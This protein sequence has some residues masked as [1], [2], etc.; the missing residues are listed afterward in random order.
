MGLMDP[1]MYKRLIEIFRVELSEQIQAITDCLLVL[2]KTPEDP[3]GEERINTI[4]RAAHN[5]KGSARGTGLENIGDIAHCLEDLFSKFRQSEARPNTA[6]CN[7]CLEALDCMGA[8]MQAHIEKTEP[9]FDLQDLLKKLEQA[10]NAQ[11]PSPKN[12]AK[13]QSTNT[14]KSEKKKDEKASGDAVQTLTADFIRIPKEK[15]NELSAVGDELLSV[16]IKNEDLTSQMKQL[17]SR[18]KSTN[19]M[20]QTVI[21]SIKR[22]SGYTSTTEIESGCATAIEQAVDINNSV[23]DMQRNM[24]S[25]DTELELIVNSLQENMRMLRLVPVGTILQPLLRTVRDIAQEL[26]KQV[27]VE[28]LGE[29]IEID[30]TILEHLRSPLIHLIRNAIDHG[31]EAPDERRRND[32]PEKGKITI[33]VAEEGSQIFISVVDDGQGINLDKI[34]SKAIEKK[35]IISEEANKLSPQD[36]LD[37]ITM[38]GFSTKEIITEVSGR[39]VGMDVVQTNVQE[40]KGT[41]QIDTKENQGTTVTM[42]LPLT[43]LTDR[44]IVVRADQQI[45][46]VPTVSVKRIL[47][48]ASEEI[49]AIEGGQAIMTEG[50]A[51]PLYHLAEM[52][53]ISDN[54]TE[55]TQHSVALVMFRGRSK[56]AFIV[57]EIMGEREIAV[58][59]LLPPLTKTQYISGATLSGRGDVLLVLYPTDLI[60]MALRT[61]TGKLRIKEKNIEQVT[62]N[63]L[64][65]DDSITTRTLEVDILKNSG[66]R[67]NSA[68]NGLEAWKCLQ[69]EDFDLVVTDI[70]M[71]VMDGFELTEKIKKDERY[72]DLPVV[73]VTVRAKSE[74]KK[75]G[76][77]VG[78]NAY[79]TKSQFETKVLLDVVNQ[80]L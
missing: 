58:K 63:I 7:L 76:V 19:K 39:G 65:V 22:Q 15:L 23:T 72:K 35:L 33:K 31:I 75:R 37:L 79:I 27:D 78:A 52:L 61:T 4:F 73:I 49:H 48:L 13:K 34:R 66:Y 40:V 9:E 56:V 38:P 57:D 20:W 69:K 62:P 32:K 53:G 36:I 80:L 51:V 6:I 25:V 5:I 12:V 46:I 68:V 3:D 2:E 14:Q 17:Q 74:D 18:I 11:E 55:T 59:P 16:R 1:K 64:V 50:Q 21:G 77:E 8:A 60:E 26:D 44:G 41:V 45:F 30:R 28:I 47:H 54:E 10:A 42:R 24:R 29:E 71:P 70:E 67:V 43:L